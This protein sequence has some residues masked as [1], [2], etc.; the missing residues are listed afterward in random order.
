MLLGGW[1][2]GEGKRTMHFGRLIWRQRKRD[3]ERRRE[4]EIERERMRDRE[5][6][7]KRENILLQNV[8]M[9]WILVNYP[10]QNDIDFNF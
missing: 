8:C 7:R 6:E 10:S 9:I 1:G 3:I 4:R 5:R 2:G